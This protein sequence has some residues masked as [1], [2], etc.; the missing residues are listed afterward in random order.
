MSEVIRDYNEFAR[1]LS[2]RGLKSLFVVCGNSFAG[3][4]PGRFLDCLAAV[5]FRIT[6][7]RDFTP[8]PDHSSVVKGIEAFRESGAAQAAVPAVQ[9][10]T[11]TASGAADFESNEIMTTIPFVKDNE[12]NYSWLSPFICK[13]LRKNIIPISEFFSVDF[14]R[15]FAVNL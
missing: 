13:M 12:F 9:T 5:G 14:V 3:I 4:A 6:Y 8:N 1:W 10:A 11:V 2:A 7:F 15:N